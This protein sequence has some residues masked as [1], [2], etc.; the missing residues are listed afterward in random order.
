MTIKLALVGCGGISRAHVTGYH[1]LVQRGCREFEVT[2]CCDVNEASAV[3]RAQEIAAFQGTQPVVLTDIADLIK[4]GIAQAADL[5]L[6]HCFHHTVAIPLLENGI[7]VM[8]EKPLGITIRASKRIIEVAEKY[9]RVLATGENIRRYP[10]AR[11][12]EWA[13]NVRRLIGDVR[14]VTIQAINY[15][16]FD[17]T[18]YATK[19]RVIKALTG[20]GM[21]MDSGAHFG[22]MIQVLFGDVDQVYCT[23]NTYDDR[24]VEGAPVV[25]TAPVDVEDTWHAVIRFKSG[26]HVTWSYSRALHEQGVRA[27]DYYGSKGTMRDLGFVFHPFQGGGKAVLV[28]GSEWSSDQIL[29]EYMA[30]LSEQDKSRLFPYGSTDGFAIEVWDFVNA[31]ATGRK[32]EM[33]GY[34]GLR[35]KAL[36]E[37]CYESATA[38]EPVKFDDVLAGRIDA[39]QQPIDAF[40]KI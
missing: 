34:D 32:P 31:I 16:P 29:A 36:C 13:I 20:G 38:G 40:W 22:D 11:A 2:A 33:D 25:G 39:Y 3:L 12:C 14:L 8:I 26:L 4:A 17:M 30:S 7:D 9:G 27:G 24:M 6:P 23:M 5:C 21:I 15:G 35:A 10:T 37:C 19:W 1:D 28:D 18:H